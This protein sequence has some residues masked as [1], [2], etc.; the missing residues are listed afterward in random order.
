[1]LQSGALSVQEANQ[2]LYKNQQLEAA[3]IGMINWRIFVFCHPGTDG[4]SQERVKSG[5]KRLKNR[6]QGPVNRAG[7]FRYF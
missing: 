3:K 4:L 5:L 6:L 1:M 2:R 7:H